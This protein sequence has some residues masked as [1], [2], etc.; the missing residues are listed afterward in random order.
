M[1]QWLTKVDH[2]LRAKGDSM[3]V[4]LVTQ[5]VHGKRTPLI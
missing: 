4:W 2:K 1:N 3:V 5:N